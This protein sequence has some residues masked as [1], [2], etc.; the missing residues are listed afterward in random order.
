[1]DDKHFD[2]IVDII[3]ARVD[4]ILNKIAIEHILSKAFEAIR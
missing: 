1:M 2:M 3:M 4:E